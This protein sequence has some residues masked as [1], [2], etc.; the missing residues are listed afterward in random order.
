MAYTLFI[1]QAEADLA[2]DLKI[3]NVEGS[4]FSYDRS[5]A[6]SIIDTILY[7]DKISETGVR[8]A[9]RVASI[10]GQEI[11]A[12]PSAPELL[13]SDVF[14]EPLPSPVAEEVTGKRPSG[15]REAPKEKEDFG[16]V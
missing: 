13:A 16:F 8:L 14:Q 9:G 5:E 7:G 11:A 6:K 12:E 3:G 4:L 10:M 1:T 2:T 15:R